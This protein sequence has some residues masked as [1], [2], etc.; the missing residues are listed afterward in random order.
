M[1]LSPRLN[2]Y[3]FLAISNDVISNKVE[4][5]PSVELDPTFYVTRRLDPVSVVEIPFLDTPSIS[6]FS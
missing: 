4:P 3:P 5:I 6:I 2:E 1:N